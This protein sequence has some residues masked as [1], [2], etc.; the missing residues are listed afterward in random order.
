MN[1][2]IKIEVG[3]NFECVSVNNGTFNIIM[4]KVVEENDS[5]SISKL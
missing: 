1:D 3:E 2:S 4:K 5:G